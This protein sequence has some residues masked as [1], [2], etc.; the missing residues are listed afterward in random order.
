M[1]SLIPQ[2]GSPGLK[3]RMILLSASAAFSLVLV[4]ALGQLS[5][6]ALKGHWLIDSKHTFYVNCVIPVPD[7]RQY[8]L[9]PGYSDRSMAINALGF[10]GPIPSPGGD[11]RLLG[12]LGDSV[13]FGA[14]VADEQAY[15]A[16]LSRRLDP[17]GS[18]WTV[19]NAGVPSYNLAQSF[20]RLRAEVL[21]KFKPD[22]V[23]IQAFNDIAL[24]AYYKDQWTPRLT[25]A[26]ALKPYGCVI[27]NPS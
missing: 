14:D 21:T 8:T 19:L 6:R 12:I 5:Y 9:R 2:I 1:P 13:P 25:W 18:C 16:V 10:R 22:L 7:S 11:R 4:E 23:V 3:S 27:S 20:E 15:P 17:A 26:D 24:L